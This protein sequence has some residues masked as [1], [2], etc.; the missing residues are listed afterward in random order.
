MKRKTAS[1]PLFLLFLPFLLFLT[2]CVDDRIHITVFHTN[3]IHGWIMARDAGK[4]D[5]RRP[6]RQ[7]GGFAALA[8]AVR[9]HGGPKLLLDAGDWFQGTPEGGLTQGRAAID[10]LGLAG[11]DATEVGNHDFD[12]GAETLKRLA[13]RSR[14]PV[15]AANIYDEKTGKR[16][17]FVQAHIL[18]D[19]GGVKVGV[20]GLLTTNMRS[21]T[22]ARNFKG[23]RFRDESEE[24]RDQVAELRAQGAEVVIAL[25]HVGF[26]RPGAAPF[27]DDQAIAAAVPGIDLIV[28]GHTHTALYRP[29]REPKNGTWIVQ[30]GHYLQHVG[31]ASLAVDRASHRLV[32]VHG[33]LE[34][35]WIDRYGQDPEL[36]AAVKGFQAEVGKELDVV[37]GSASAALARSQTEESAMG[38]WM[39]DCM[40]DWGG[41]DAAFQNAGGIRSELDAGPVTLR[42][43]Y[44]VMPFDNRMVVLRLGG[45]ALREV[46][47]NGVNGAHGLLQVSGVQLRY[48]PQ[49]PAGRRLREASVAGKPLQ[50]SRLYDVVATDF[51]VMGG[52]GYTAFGKAARK[53][54]KETLLREVLARCVKKSSR[55]SPPT[56]GRL[57]TAR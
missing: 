23:L 50:D 55:I 16:V 19:V 18:K 17:P 30:A 49:A 41:A 44:E 9:A 56:G 40:R 57:M 27:Q 38:D 34:P 33:R 20:F 35:L 3:D 39:T 31:V 47:E 14:I 10:L 21:L 32:H 26:R 54:E 51:M 22:F 53:E 11:F 12:F 2:S 1:Y 15:L 6:K 25:T 45:A 5:S 28:G 36:L 29:V 8:S 4:L 42:E 52:D 48:D 13:R 37:I 46:L 43:V 7:L 24:A